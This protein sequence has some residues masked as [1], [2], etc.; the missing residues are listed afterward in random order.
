VNLTEDDWD[1]VIRVNLRATFL[2]S[3]AAA[4]HWRERHKAGDPLSG[5]LINT[6]SESGVFANAGQANYGAAKSGVATLTQI[7]AKELKRYG[8]RANA[9]LPRARTRLTEGILG[10]P[11][12][13]AVFDRWH[14]AN[15]SPFVA[16]LATPG[17]PFTGETFLVGGSSIQ[18]VRPWE[19]DDD[20]KL[21]GNGRWTI[22]ELMEIGAT[23]G[24]MSPA[25]GGGLIT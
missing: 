16:F 14:P 6:S 9:V 15:V 3:Q 21:E 18:R 19:L 20:W 5:S 17:C 1:V 7:C 10:A 13:T 8:A 11:K 23:R 25:S 24:P 22:T 2:T 12:S 4:R